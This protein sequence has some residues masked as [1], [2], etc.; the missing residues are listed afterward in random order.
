MSVQNELLEDQL[1]SFVNKFIQKD[2]LFYD[3]YYAARQIKEYGVR[4]EKKEEN[5]A[6]NNP[7]VP[8]V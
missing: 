3:G 4:H 1:D 2:K 8:A 5:N 6:A 7:S